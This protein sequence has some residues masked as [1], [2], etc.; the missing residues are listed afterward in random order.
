MKIILSRKGVDSSSGRMPSPIFPDGSLVSL[1]IPDKASPITY[2]GIQAHNGWNMGELVAMLSGKPTMSAWRAHLD[3]DLF[4]GAMHRLKGWKAVFGQQGAA[5]GHLRNH[6]ISN[7][8][9]FLFFGLFRE[10]VLK[11]GKLCWKS[12]SPQKHVI[13]GWLQ[14]ETILPVS[15]QTLCSYPW[16]DYHPHAYGDRIG[17]NVWYIA[18]EQ[19]SL[20]DSL[21]NIRGG[22]IFTHFAPS[23]QLTTTNQNKASCW[24]LPRW[25]HPSRREVTFSR[26]TNQ[27]STD[28]EGMAQLTPVGQWQECILHCHQPINVKIWLENIFRT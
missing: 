7:G 5:Q 8:D 9:L 4:D 2:E 18:K 25:M 28:Q 6:D 11:N 14:T 24:S 16:L 26:F 10:T 13:W 22:G 3:P 17:Q 12:D 19:L 23:R 1:P 21:L 20:F 27:W 15:E